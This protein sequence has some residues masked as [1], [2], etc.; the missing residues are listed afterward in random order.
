MRCL[1]FVAWSLTAAALACSPADPSNAASGSAGPATAAPVELAPQSELLQTVR[2][3]ESARRVE[4]VPREALR[5]TD[6]RTRVAA[7]RALARIAGPESKKQL[8][9]MLVDESPDVVKWAA[10]GIGFECARDVEWQTKHLSEVDAVVSALAARA[11]TLPAEAAWDAAHDA[12]VRALA[13]CFKSSAVESTLVAWLPSERRGCAA[14]L[15]LGDLAMRTKKLR[16]ETWVTLLNRAAGSVSAAPCRAAF[17]AFARVPHLPPSVEPRFVEV[18]GTALSV[19]DPYRLMLVR[20]LSRGGAAAVP[21]LQRVLI[22]EPASFSM[23]ERLEAFR[24]ALRLEKPANELVARTLEAWTK[25]DKSELADGGDSVQL[26]LAV[27]AALPALPDGDR[28]KPQLEKLTALELDSPSARQKRILSMLRCRALAK[29]APSPHDPALGKCDADYA[30]ERKRAQLAVMAR[31]AIGPKELVLFDTLAKDEDALVQEAALAILHKQ[32]TLPRV[33]TLTRALA[34]KRS[35]IAIFALEALADHPS[36]GARKAA[37]KAAKGKDPES[38][39]GD[40]STVEPDEAVVAALAVALERGAA[41]QEP[42]MLDLTIRAIGAIGAQTLRSKIEPF[43]GAHQPSTR[44]ATAAALKLLIGKAPR[45]DA[46]TEEA[47]AATLA[48]APAKA[49]LTF[50]TDAG[51]LVITLDGRAAPRATLRFVDLVKRGYYN[52]NI[53]H[54]VDP[55]YVVQFGSPLGDG[56]GGPIED[57]P[58]RCETGPLAY[59]EKSVGVAL[60]GRDTGKSQLFVT[61][62]RHPHID[63]AYPLI[64][65]AE[66]PWEKVVEGDIIRAARVDVSE[67]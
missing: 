55:S 40:V 28:W 67:D 62:A 7:A 26:A 35:G 29:W 39:E 22:D 47:K 13:G 65:K 60:A 48:D 50:E 38:K 58:L 31:S 34:E 63:G 42:E 64:G 33:A 10:Y 3:A 20:A 61:R 30:A 37:K 51:E 46:P 32:E 6:A 27:L 45:C 14:A 15:A 5:S 66:G 19:P 16:E 2:G 57:A 56:Y 18:A 24:A 52:G 49:Q 23:P 21:L 12:L 44:E 54:R 4:G 25:L 9:T 41:E 17:F 11:T 43:C 8:I 59:E 53:L 1:H 36:L